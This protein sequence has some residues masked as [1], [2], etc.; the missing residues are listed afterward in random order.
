MLLIIQKA[1][2]LSVIFRS[3][4]KADSAL[5]CVKGNLAPEGSMAKI[6]GKETIFQGNARVYASEED[7]L[8]RYFKRVKWLLKM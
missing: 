4:I 8:Q 3:T 1:K 6:T 5:D 2:T 7:A